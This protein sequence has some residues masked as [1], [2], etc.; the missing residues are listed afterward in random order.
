MNKVVYSLSSEKYA[1]EYPITGLLDG[2]F[3]RYQEIAQ[4]VFLLEASTRGDTPS[5]ASAPNGRSTLP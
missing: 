4:G 5:R 1:Q 2:W 3:F